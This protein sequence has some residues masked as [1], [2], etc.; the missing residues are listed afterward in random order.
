V[1]LAKN[2]AFFPFV[3]VTALAM[4][5][6]AALVLRAGPLLIL[7]GLVQAPSAFMLFCLVCNT[8]AILAPY[9]FSPGTLQAKKPTAVV[10]IANLLIF[11]M[12]PLVALPLALPPGLQLLFSVQGWAGGYLM[13][14]LAATLLLAAIGFFYWRLLPVQGRLLQTRER[15]VLQAVTQANE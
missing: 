14:L 8:T 5:V 2:L 9:R 10:I 3:L 4:L 7:P 6:V 1:L 13:N 15:T 12:M 11:L